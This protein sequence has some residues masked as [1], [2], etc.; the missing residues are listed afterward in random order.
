VWDNTT[1]ASVAGSVVDA[2]AGDIVALRNDSANFVDAAPGVGK[3]V[4]ILGVALGG[5]DA[6]NYQLASTSATATATITAVPVVVPPVEP[7]VVP[8]VVV[9]VVAPVVSPVVPNVGPSEANLSQLQ[10]LRAT[11]PVGRSWANNFAL[12]ATQTDDKANTDH[13][14]QSVHFDFVQI[15]KEP[16]LH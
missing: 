3:R 15:C 14:Y 5:V 6:A 2:V 11:V 10:T 7:P 12:A 13:C 16:N 8:P 4:N 9:P 1:T